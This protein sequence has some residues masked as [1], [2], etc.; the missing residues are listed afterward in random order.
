[1]Q[2]PVSHMTDAELDTE[3][4]A[5]RDW[6]EHVDFQ[7]TNYPGDEAILADLDIADK[8]QAEIQA[9][10]GRRLDAIEQKAAEFAYDRMV[11][12]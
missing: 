7:L 3:W 5:L 10:Q 9:E 1:M 8:R 11:E 4:Y 2:K 6:M 12:A